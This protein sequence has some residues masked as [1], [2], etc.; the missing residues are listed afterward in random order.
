MD[1]FFWNKNNIAN[2]YNTIIRKNRIANLTEDKKSELIKILTDEMKTLNKSIDQNKVRNKSKDELDAALTSLNGKILTKI[3]DWLTNSTHQNRSIQPSIRN[4]GFAPIDNG[5]TLNKQF[6]PYI[7]QQRPINDRNM[8]DDMDDTMDDPRK[9]IESLTEE[10]NRAIPLRP[11]APQEVPDFLI[12]RDKN[13]K[14]DYKHA[15]QPSQKQDS[16]MQGSMNNQMP[17]HSQQDN[18]MQYQQRQGMNG[19]VDLSGKMTGT[20]NYNSPILEQYSTDHPIDAMAYNTADQYASNLNQFTTGIDPKLFDQFQE[21]DTGAAYERMEKLRTEA[22]N[23]PQTGQSSS[24]QQLTSG[25]NNTAPPPEMRQPQMQQMQMQQMQP[26]RQPIQN[27]MMALPDHGQQ[28]IASI[29]RRPMETHSTAMPPINDIK[30]M[31]ENQ[32]LLANELRSLRAQLQNKNTII[33]PSNPT[34]LVM[35]I[36]Q[37]NSEIQQYKTVN[38]SLNNQLEDLKS[39]VGTVDIEKAQLLENKKNEIITELAKIKDEHYRLEIAIKKQENMEVI[40][41]RKK[42]E[43]LATIKKYDYKIFGGEHEFVIEYSDLQKIDEEKPI[44]RYELPYIIDNMMQLTLIEQNFNKIMFNISPYN[45][46]FNL[47]DVGDYEPT[48]EKSEYI[49]YRYGKDYNGRSVLEILVEPGNYELDVLISKLNLVLDKYDIAIGYDPTKYIVQIRS[50]KN[51]QFTL[52]KDQYDIYSTL[53]FAV[54]DIKSEKFRASTAVNLKINKIMSCYVMNID[55]KKPFAKVNLS[56]DKIVGNIGLIIKPYI[57]NLT[58]L[59]FCFMNE[60]NRPYWQ[61]YSNFNFTIVI[62]GVVAEKD[63]DKALD[64]HMTGEKDSTN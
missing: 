42:E 51:I 56:S 30:E 61:E 32:I 21:R 29:N 55:Q 47:A 28:A 36:N 58:Y 11:M 3:S 54:T 14:K 13:G 26:M 1:N 6:N 24:I 63:K 57:N 37:L 20:D 33:N 46:K 23:V 25:G 15:P 59:D 27:N 60:S 39:K 48:T 40:L 16:H 35:Q 44:Y 53:G 19:Q 45:N 10:R 62:K 31:Y 5:S 12:P 7:T 43:V 38:M 9:R 4:Q 52:I 8:R 49:N 17:H 2:L 50:K 64:Q 22:A 18:Q 41:D 34:D